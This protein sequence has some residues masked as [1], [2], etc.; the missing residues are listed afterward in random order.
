MGTMAGLKSFVDENEA[1]TRILEIVRRDEIAMA[2]TYKVAKEPDTHKEGRAT[3]R[4]R[5]DV[6]YANTKAQGWNTLLWWEQC[7]REYS[8]TICRRSCT[9]SRGLHPLRAI[10]FHCFTYSRT[11]S[12]L[13]GLFGFWL[14]VLVGRFCCWCCFVG[15]LVFP[16]FLHL[17][18]TRSS[19]FPRLSPSSW[20]AQHWSKKKIG[21]QRRC[22]ATEVHISCNTF[23]SLGLLMG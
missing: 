17:G 15:W 22:N 20:W 8:G 11:T 18:C 5:K 14:F 16:S 7:I 13:V 1:V 2:I 21:C 6:P 12:V 10:L 9:E 19:S 4:R 23:N 3:K